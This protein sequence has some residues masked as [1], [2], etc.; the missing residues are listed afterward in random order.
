MLIICFNGAGN[1]Q[2]KRLGRLF[3]LVFGH[4]RD[5]SSDLTGE[6]SVKTGTLKFNFLVQVME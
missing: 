1:F 5:V 6:R 4:F 2:D 3:F